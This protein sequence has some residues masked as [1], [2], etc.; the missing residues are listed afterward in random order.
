MDRRLLTTARLKRA[1]H[2][3]LSRD[4]FTRRAEQMQR[5]LRRH[6]GPEEATDLILRLAETRTA[7]QRTSLD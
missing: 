4:S 6:N 3:L 2:T 1:I 7:V 5:T